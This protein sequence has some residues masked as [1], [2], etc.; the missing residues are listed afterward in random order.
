M[1]RSI[2]L[3]PFALFVFRDEGEGPNSDRTYSIVLPSTTPV[4]SVSWSWK[5]ITRDEI[6]FF[7]DASFK[8]TRVHVLSRLKTGTR[9]IQSCKKLERVGYVLPERYI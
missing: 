3:V 6:F 8:S 9:W 7:N 4:S 2:R 1:P 5:M